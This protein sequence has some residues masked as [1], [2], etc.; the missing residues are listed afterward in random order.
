MIEMYIDEKS[1]RGCE[2]CIEICPTDVIVSGF[3]N[4]VKIAIVDKVEDCIA[5]L[6]CSFK[7]PSNAIEH[8]N[9]HIVQNFYRDI[10]FI[11]KLR[12]FI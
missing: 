5:C 3:F 8:R 9:H 1:C 12:K 4:D 11:E 10:R 7:C 6:S 2:L